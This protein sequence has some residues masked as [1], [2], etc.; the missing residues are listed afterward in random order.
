MLSAEQR[1]LHADYRKVRNF[2]HSR[3]IADL[4]ASYGFVQPSYADTQFQLN[5]TEMTAEYSAQSLRGGR[6]TWKWR[7]RT[8]LWTGT[9]A[10]SGRKWALYPT[11][12]EHESLANLRSA[13]MQ[14]SGMEYAVVSRWLD[15]YKSYGWG[16]E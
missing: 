2:E 5:H 15:L 1:K 3:F 10:L 9:K 8:M 13:M 14:L 6:T 11:D 4:I 12:A 16:S 7:C